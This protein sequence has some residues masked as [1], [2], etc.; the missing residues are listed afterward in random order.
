[1]PRNYVL[2]QSEPGTM[3]RRK[4][5]EI[6][7]DHCKDIHHFLQREYYISDQNR[8][9]LFIA[10]VK[11]LE[12]FFR[13]VNM[14]FE[15]GEAICLS[16]KIRLL[17]DHTE[18]LNS[19]Q[20][21]QDNIIYVCE[22]LH[23]EIP[24]AYFLKIEQEIDSW[25]NKTE[26]FLKTN[27]SFLND[28]EIILEMLP[29]EVA[30]ATIK[31]YL[32]NILYELN[33]TAENCK[34]E[35]NLFSLKNLLVDLLNNWDYVSNFLSQKCEFFNKKNLKETVQILEA[36]S[37]NGE[38]MALLEKYNNKLFDEAENQILDNIFEKIQ[39]DK[40]Q[41]LKLL[42]QKLIIMQASISERNSLAMVIN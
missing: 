16:K 42:E 20:S 3:K 2:A 25:I 15:N 10:A 24:L 5:I 13:L 28:K 7:E 19:L 6:V 23:K 14:Q 11:E 37:T 4:L 22:S 8:S 33:I 39:M 26:I 40:G 32:D 29:K 38:D 30:V 18:S 9:K 31:K 27:F 21:H 12:S 34:A 1:M 41:L 36:Y 17:V 35:G